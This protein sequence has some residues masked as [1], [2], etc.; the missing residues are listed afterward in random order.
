MSYTFE[1]NNARK[2]SNFVS[3]QIKAN[4]PVV[5][6]F[7]AMVQG[8]DL[9]P[10]G[11][12]ADKAAKYIMELNSKAAEGD[13]TAAAEL[14]SI[15]RLM[16]EPLLKEE[17]KLLGI[18]GSYQALGFDES[19]E[20]EVTDIANAKGNIQAIGQ[21][22]NFPV[23]RKKRLPIATTTI[24]GGFAVDYR[25]AALGDM[26]KENEAMNQVRID[27][28]NKAA[29]YVV[30]T[31][32]AAIT[33][34]SGVKYTFEAAGLTKTGVDGVLAKIR[35]FGKPNILGTYALLAEFNG[36]AGYA[37]V[38]PAVTGIPDAIMNEIHQNGIMGAYNGSIL[39]E[40]P[41]P[42][43]MASFNTVTSNFDTYL[44]EGLGFVVPTGADSPIRTVTRGGLTSMTGN[45][46]TTGQTISRMDIEVGTIVCPGREFQIGL[47]KDTNL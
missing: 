13:F 8:K 2:D 26:S 4:S 17:I 14:N 42:Y 25:R 3:G 22:V 30:D 23:V 28:R 15:R 7:S 21:D 5:E 6:I 47:I 33:G 46:V 10:Y 32:Y 45:D 31:V 20:I 38:T 34:A 36:F 9:A 19:C 18:F 44:P 39:S 11:A 37:G 1:L 24:S 29:K 35:K 16:V 43:D 12:K 40:I 27:I 41:N